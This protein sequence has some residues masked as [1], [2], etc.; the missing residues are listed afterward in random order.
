MKT[1][2]LYTTFVNTMKTNILYP[3]YQKLSHLNTKTRNISD[4][5]KDMYGIIV[6]TDPIPNP[7]VK[8]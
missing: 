6:G 3:A 5:L 8:V 4:K 1:I 7:I 2:R